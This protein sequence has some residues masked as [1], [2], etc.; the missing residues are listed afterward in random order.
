MEEPPL[1]ASWKPV[2]RWPGA[3]I[4]AMLTAPQAMTAVELPLAELQGT[5]Y[6]AKR[7]VV[8]A[9]VHIQPILKVYRAG[10]RSRI[11]VTG[12]GVIISKEGYVLTN[13]HVV[14]HAE[15]VTCTLHDQQVAYLLAEEAVA[16]AVSVELQRLV[17]LARVVRGTD[18][19]ARGDQDRNDEH[20][21]LDPR[22]A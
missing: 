19:D 20:R 6:E 16:H 11:A 17:V 10:E 8:P 18:R 5:V 1:R 12:S 13:N 4:L 3:L 15:R 9:L 2:R 22:E 14:E 21:S 7:K